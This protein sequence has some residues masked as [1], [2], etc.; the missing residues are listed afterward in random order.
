MATKLK[1]SFKALFAKQNLL[2]F[3]INLAIFIATL[4][5]GQDE[6][7]RNLLVNMGI[8]PD[9]AILV[10]SGILLLAKEFVIKYGT[11]QTTTGISEPTSEPIPTPD[12]GV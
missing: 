11:V 8:N 5:T 2:H 10:A 12:S 7:V 3:G 6:A 9:T 4:L 1:F